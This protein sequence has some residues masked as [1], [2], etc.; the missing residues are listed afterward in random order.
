MA[1]KHSTVATTLKY[2]VSVSLKV[3]KVSL[4][5]L[6]PVFLVVDLALS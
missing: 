3:L 2:A 4:L 6:F 1:C 5:F